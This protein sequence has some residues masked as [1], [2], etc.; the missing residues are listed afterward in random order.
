MTL[1]GKRQ[2]LNPSGR[3]LAAS[4]PLFAE[5]L[6]R[7]FILAAFVV[8]LTGLPAAAQIGP[9]QPRAQPQSYSLGVGLHNAHS[10]WMPYDY[11]I[12]RNRVYV[13]GSYAVNER[14]EAFGRAGGSD[15]VINDL[16]TFQPGMGYDVHVDGYPAFFSGG[17]R[18]C[19]WQIGRWSI[20]ASLEA[21]WYASTTKTI[22]WTWDCY[23]ELYFDSTTEITAAL[24]VGF[25]LGRGVIYAGPLLHFA[26]T[27]ADVR[28]HEFGP[29]WE[30]E[31]H[32]DDRTI[33]DKGG[34]GAFLGWQT[35]LGENGWHLD[36]EGSVLRDGVGGALG[37]YRAW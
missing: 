34:W 27:R 4:L 28:T 12:D 31:D 20:G 14:L 15:W 8:L 2:T 32:I 7:L 11:E 13:E 18:G 29:D 9:P 5:R 17:L 10:R 23:Q 22:R 30:I 6:M 25:N 35:P 19:A 33:R 37:F 21:A 36:L 24:P 26:Y 1:L 3:R 16:Q